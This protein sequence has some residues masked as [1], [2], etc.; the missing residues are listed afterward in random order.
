MS[1]TNHRVDGGKD[2]GTAKTAFRLKHKKAGKRSASNKRR[3]WRL[4]ISRA[5][6]SSMSNGQ[7]SPGAQWLLATGDGGPTQQEARASNAQTSRLPAFLDARSNQPR[8][9]LEV[10]RAKEARCTPRRRP[11][12]STQDGA[13]ARTGVR[14]PGP[15]GPEALALRGTAFGA[16]GHNK[17]C[18]TVLSRAPPS[19]KQH[20]AHSL[21]ARQTNLILKGGQTF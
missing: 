6:A 4:A 8:P 20:T 7:G 21:I 19:E 16:T 5:P 9:T 18:C 15:K 14:R 1:Q 3:G 10:R 2:L 13:A 17:L 12:E 11:P